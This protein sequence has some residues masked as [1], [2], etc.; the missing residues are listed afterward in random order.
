MAVANTATYY[1]T[2][3]IVTIEKIYSAGLERLYLINFRF[4]LVFEMVQ[5]FEI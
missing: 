5:I 3:T 2:T 4:L 1:D